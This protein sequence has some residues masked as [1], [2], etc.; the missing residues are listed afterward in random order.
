MTEVPRPTKEIDAAKFKAAIVCD[1]C[2]KNNAA[3]VCASPFGPVSYAYCTECLGNG[4]DPESS[5][6]YLYWFVGSRGEGLAEG[7]KEA[8]TFKDGRYWKWEEWKAWADQQ[9]MPD[10]VKK[11]MGLDDDKEV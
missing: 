5:F 11:A 6:E 1:V 9:P 10:Y 2:N 3:G 4:A 8:A 7:V